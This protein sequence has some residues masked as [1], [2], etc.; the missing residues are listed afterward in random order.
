MFV[1]VIQVVEKKLKGKEEAIV[2]LLKPE[3][4]HTFYKCFFVLYSR[5]A[6]R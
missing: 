2:S 6:F 4:L 1:I 3:T 5:T